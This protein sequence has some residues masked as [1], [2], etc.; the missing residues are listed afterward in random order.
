[1]SKKS[2]RA[3][4]LL[5]ARRH[6]KREARLRR[7]RKAVPR[8]ALVRSTSTGYEIVAPNEVSLGLSLY[9]DA[10]AA[11]LRSL[12]LYRP[13][14][15]ALH[16][17]FGSTTSFEVS[18]TLV[19]KATIDGLHHKYGK[20]LLLTA[21]L[22]KNGRER[23]VLSHVGIMSVIGQ[24]PVNVSQGQVTR[25]HVFDGDDTNCQEIG[26]AIERLST[27]NLSKLLFKGA[28][29]GITNVVHHS[30]INEYYRSPHW[31][32]FAKHD[33]EGLTVAIC[34]LGVGIPTSLPAKY[35]DEIVLKY[36]PFIT[37]PGT[38]DARLIDAATRLARSRTNET[39]RG[40]GLGNM[41][42]V[43]EAVQDSFLCVVSNRGMLV[44]Q[45]RN[46]RVERRKVKLESELR[47]TLA[48]WNIKPQEMYPALSNRHGGEK[49]TAR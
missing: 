35:P 38:R 16:I 34:D 3:A 46:G 41:V 25:W 40:L 28:S 44:I 37:H 27:S 11:F 31:W 32:M 7:T 2:T 24:V 48:V 39:N 21:S 23:E 49:W 17:N 36:L 33:M 10:T 8:R 22:P 14:H 29:E 19:M 45:N 18:A 4:A 47:G 12:R 13:S 15:G 43:I 30:E 9:R 6:R 5:S 20:D 26:E 42:S 1:M